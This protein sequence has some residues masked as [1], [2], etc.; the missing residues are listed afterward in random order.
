MTL[1]ITKYL[2]YRFN[3]FLES[4]GQ[5]LIKIKHRKVTGDY[6]VAEEIQNQNWQHFI[7]RVW[8]VCQAKEVGSRIR[9]S[10]DFLLNTAENVTIAKKS[11][12]TFYNVIERN[13][14]STMQK[15]SVEVR[16]KINKDFLREN[17]W[18]ENVVS[19]LDCWFAFYFQHGKFPGS[20]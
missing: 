4:Q 5:L 9:K 15:L 6:I 2:L 1:K 8:E 7:E 14:Y 18:A 10:E 11:Y 13:F 20:Q 3:D 17:F 16:D 12:E 19:N